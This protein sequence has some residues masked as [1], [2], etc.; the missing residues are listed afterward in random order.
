MKQIERR[1]FYWNTL[2]GMVNAGQSFVYLFVI[3]WICGLEAAGLFSF[4]FTNANLFLCIGKYGMRKF[5][6]TDLNDEYKFQDYFIS[7][8]ITTSIMIL[9]ITV[10]SI[11]NNANEKNYFYK[12]MVLILIGVLKSVDSID[13]VYLGLF[14]QKKRLDIGARNSCLRNVFTIALIVFAIYITKN[15]LISFC[16]G[17]IASISILIFLFKK[18]QHY[19]QIERN[20]KVTPKIIRRLL[21]ISTPLAIGDFLAFYIIN[22]PKYSIDS[23]LSEEIQAYY[24]I[25]SMPILLIA[26][27]SDFVFN[28]LLVRFSECWYNNTKEFVKLLVRQFLLIITCTFLVILLGSWIGLPI[29]GVVYNVDLDA[30]RAEFIILL[31][32]GGFAAA[33]SFLYSLVTAIR[34]QRCVLPIYSIVAIIIFIISDYI[35]MKMQLMGASLIYLG[36]SA[37]LTVLFISVLVWNLDKLNGKRGKIECSI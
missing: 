24:G 5:Q 27:F 22:A 33:S 21:L 19:I 13:D 28:P 25:I 18:S 23:N 26:L 2:A 34:K 16:I 29:L 36:A 10:Y 37:I 6:A 12:M 7:R 32:G 15:I 31:I 35:V 30:Y 17:T 1:S 14:Q 9:G 20:A 8:I 4:A 11:M 3:R